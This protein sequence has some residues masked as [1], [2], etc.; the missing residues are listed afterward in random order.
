MQAPKILGL[1]DPTTLSTPVNGTDRQTELLSVEP[2]T[3]KKIAK[4]ASL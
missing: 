1:H 2:S 3:Q 4:L